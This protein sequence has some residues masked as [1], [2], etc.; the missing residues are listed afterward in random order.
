MNIRYR[1]LLQSLENSP[2]IIRDYVSQIPESDLDIKRGPDCWTL[3]EHIVHLEYVQDIMYQR[4]ETIKNEEKPVIR[5]YFPEQDR[6]DTSKTPDIDITLQSFIDKRNRQITLIHSLSEKDWLKEARHD[7]YRRYTIP[8][9]LH[10]I[11][12]HDQWHMYRLEELWL[13]RDEFF[14]G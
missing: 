14:R 5:P 10:H 2:L 8:L 11:L 12:W 6:L 9:F 1:P 3:R 4:I 13:T 7:E